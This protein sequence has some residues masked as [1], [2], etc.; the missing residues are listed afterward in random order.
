VAIGRLEPGASATWTLGPGRGAYIYLVDGRATLNGRPLAT[1][2]AAKVV[3]E[4]AIELAGGEVPAEV[5]L[6]D[7]PMSWTPVGVW[8]R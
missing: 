6:V 2:D 7:V 3:D 1:G 8:A 5:I 4:P